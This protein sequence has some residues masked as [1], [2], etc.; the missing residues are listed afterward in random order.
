MEKL[1]KKPEPGT[2]WIPTGL[3]EPTLGRVSPLGTRQMS[4]LKHPVQQFD[5]PGLLLGLEEG[6]SLRGPDFADPLGH[7]FHTGLLHQGVVLLR[8]QPLGNQG[9]IEGFQQHLGHRE[10]A[11]PAG[12][13]ATSAFQQQLPWA[14]WH[15]QHGTAPTW[16]FK[17]KRHQPCLSYCCWCPHP[18]LPEGYEDGSDHSMH[19]VS[20]LT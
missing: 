18:T 15:S 14:P 19:T 6:E 1:R 10:S 5:L 17:T 12:S 3:G 11:E 7:V 4:H 9:E 16:T 20:T 8:V 13:C 2:Q